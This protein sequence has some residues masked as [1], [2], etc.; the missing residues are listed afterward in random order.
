MWIKICPAYTCSFSCCDNSTVMTEE[1]QSWSF[2]RLGPVRSSSEGRFCQNPNGQPRHWNSWWG[3]APGIC[4]FSRVTVGGV[5]VVVLF[6][7]VLLCLSGHYLYLGRRVINL[8]WSQPQA[9]LESFPQGEPGERGVNAPWGWPFICP[10]EV[11]VWPSISWAWIAEHFL[12]DGLSSQAYLY[13][14]GCQASSLV[15]GR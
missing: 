1:T 9:L 10:G 2:F 6:P 8:W 3:P 14:V 4:L 12:T 13:T 7:K 15:G 5:G 11:F